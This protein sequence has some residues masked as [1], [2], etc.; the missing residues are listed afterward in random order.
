ML[1]TRSFPLDENIDS[2]WSS[3]TLETGVRLIFNNSGSVNL[4]RQNGILLKPLFDNGALGG[5][6]FNQR[7]TLEHDGVL[8]HYVYPKSANSSIASAWSV[9][10][11]VPSNISL[12]L[13]KNTRAAVLVVLTAFARWELT[14]GRAAA[15]P[16]VTL[17]EA[18]SVV[19]RRIS[20]N[21]DAINK[22]RMQ[23]SSHCMLFTTEIG[24]TWIMLNS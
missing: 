2:Y 7:L 20:L 9:C 11:F 8:R 22:R 3:E 16:R 17:G 18:A 21:T 5:R 24:L 13:R 6:Q 14:D 10:D 1:N 4:I 19:V 15:A 23:S 12:L